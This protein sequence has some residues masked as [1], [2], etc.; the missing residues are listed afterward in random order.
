MTWR[1]PDS[2]VQGR[3]VGGEVRFPR[4]ENRFGK[5]SRDESMQSQGQS[6]GLRPHLFVCLSGPMIAGM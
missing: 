6:P 3:E 4:G 5:L 1:E 2:V